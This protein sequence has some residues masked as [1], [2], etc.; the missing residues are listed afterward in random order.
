MSEYSCKVGKHS[1]IWKNPPRGNSGTTQVIIEGKPVE[2]SWR[3]DP[4]GI[5]IELPHGVFGYSILG[6]ADDDGLSR[7]QVSRRNGSAPD[8][9]WS[10]LAMRREGEESLES[11]QASTVKKGMRVRAQMPGKIL[12]L[13]VKSGELV[14]KDQPLLVMEAMKMENMIRAPQAGKVG[15]LKV[16]AGQAVE[17]GADLC[18]IDPV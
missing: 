12:R 5:W 14:A 9:T 10:G 4:E 6:Y 17:T 18:V 11:A 15:L 3:K 16:E 13:D 1:F 8:E 7:F 2:M